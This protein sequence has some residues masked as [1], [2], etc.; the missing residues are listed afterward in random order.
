MLL[1]CSLTLDL[2]SIIELPTGA[3]V[4]LDRTNATGAC[5]AGERIFVVAKDILGNYGFGVAVVAVDE[6]GG[7]SGSGKIKRR[8][9]KVNL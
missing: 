9:E 6:G 2:A 1:A 3:T 7:G 8:R 4:D 5:V